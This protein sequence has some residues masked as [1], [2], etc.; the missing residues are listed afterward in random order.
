MQELPYFEAFLAQHPD[1]AVLAVHSG[2]IVEDVP[3]W[4]SAHDYSLP[5]AVDDSGSLTALLGASSML[6][7][8]LVLDGDGIVIYN[9]PGA[10]S[11]ELLESLYLRAMQ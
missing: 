6:P 7:H 5:F 2:P 11:P 3:A 9:A 8:T 10:V 4:V 1:A